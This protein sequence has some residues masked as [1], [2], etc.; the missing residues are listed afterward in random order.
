MQFC[1]IFYSLQALSTFSLTHDQVVA[2]RILKSTFTNDDSLQSPGNS[3]SHDRP[4]TANRSFNKDDRKTKDKG[5]K[6]EPVNNKLKET[7]SV[8]RGLYMVPSK[9]GFPLVLFASGTGKEII[10]KRNWLFS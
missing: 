1:T 6:K 8:K 10:N 5:K 4:P 9:G 3:A 7:G 2:R